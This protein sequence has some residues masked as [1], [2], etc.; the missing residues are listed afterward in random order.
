MAIKPAPTGSGIVFVRRDVCGHGEIKASLE[1]VRD[2]LLATTIGVNGTGITTVEHLLSALRGMEVDNAVVEVEGPEVPIMDGSALPYV[3]LLKEAGFIEQ[4]ESQSYLVV[5]RKV[6]VSDGAGFAVFA[7]HDQ[8]RI[9][10]RIDFPHP[11]I[12]EQS[13]DLVLSS[14]TYE[15][16]ICGARTFGFLKEVE[17]LQAKGLA[18]GGSLK[19]AIVLSDD[20]IVNKEGLR[21]PDEFVRHKVLDAIG[22]LSLLGMPIKGHYVASKTGHKLNYLL[23]RELLADPD[24]YEIVGNGHNFLSPWS[25]G[26]IEKEERLSAV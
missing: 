6:S 19:N 22:D 13:L 5:K 3:K 14:A 25:Q 17:Y 24:N 2:T 8:F 7:P 9:S 10:C 26:P 1:N 11:L 16:E 18:L 23:L 15:E 12:G 21:R 20:R 4:A